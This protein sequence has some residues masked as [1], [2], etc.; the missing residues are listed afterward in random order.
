MILLALKKLFG[1]LPV[2]DWLILGATV[3]AVGY[4]VITLE[5][6]KF[7]AR[8]AENAVWTAR[9]A[10]A[11]ASAQADHDA[12]QAKVDASTQGASA[13][14][15]AKL[16]ALDAKVK[17]IGVAYA[18]KTALPASCKLDDERVRLANSALGH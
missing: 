6:A 2:E 10:A 16:D 12:M 13:D 4:H 11:N 17:R 18:P 8:A 7:Q 9:L 5:Q 3:C 1:L 15:A 14:V